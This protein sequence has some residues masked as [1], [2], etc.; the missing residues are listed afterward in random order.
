MSEF[1]VL[2]RLAEADHESLRMQELGSSV[3]LSQSAL[4]RTVARLEKEGLVERCLCAEDRRGVFVRLN[5][6]GRVRHA[7]AQPT[8]RAVIS[9]TLPPA[10][11]R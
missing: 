4:S 2:D 10:A 9:A 11:P 7:Q 3:H 6:A 8:Q 1:E 5:E